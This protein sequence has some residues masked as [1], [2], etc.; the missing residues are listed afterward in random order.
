[1]TRRHPRPRSPPAIDSCSHCWRPHGVRSSS[2]GD[3]DNPRSRSSASCVLQRCRPPVLRRSPGNP[4]E[5]DP[6]SAPKTTARGFPRVWNAPQSDG[7]SERGPTVAKDA[8]EAGQTRVA[9]SSDGSGKPRPRHSRQSSSSYRC[10]GWGR[11]P[12]AFRS[13]Q[14][15]AARPRNKGSPQEHSR[16]G[17]RLRCDVLRVASRHGRRHNPEKRLMRGREPA[18]C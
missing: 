11:S 15:R 2:L 8:M 1:M 12:R 6:R 17:G 18:L 4:N 5:G 9:R 10:G 7:V 16:K 13:R 14:T 3:R